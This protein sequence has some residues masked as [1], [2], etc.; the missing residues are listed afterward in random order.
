MP[1]GLDSEI[2]RAREEYKLAEANAE[3][4]K[5]HATDLARRAELKGVHLRALERAA[6]LRPV[7]HETTRSKAD[8]GGS[9]GRQPGSISHVWRS[10]LLTVAASHSE[11]ATEDEILDIARTMPTLQNIRHKDVHA[12]MERYLE[13]GYVESRI[14]NRWC[15]TYHARSK[16][17]SDAD[18]ESNN[19]PAED[20]IETADAA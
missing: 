6:E 2:Q 1:D 11:G 7:R 14:G 13:Y 12:R 4:A 9:R 17:A 20:E 3:A 8:A 15:V 18:S 5:A 19:D 10:V 16:F